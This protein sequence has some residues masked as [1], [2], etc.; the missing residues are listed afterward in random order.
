MTRT[1]LDAGPLVAYMN[2]DDQFHGW[3]ISQMKEL[4]EYF[5]E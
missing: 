2:E 4:P 1:L 3:A 5:P